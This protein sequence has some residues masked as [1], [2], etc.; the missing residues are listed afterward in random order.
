MMRLRWRRS[1]SKK[2]NRNGRDKPNALENVQKS[3]VKEAVPVKTIRGLKR[4]I[5]DP[6]FNIQIMTVLLTMNSDNARMDRG[7][8]TM[9][10]TV[11]KVRNITELINNSMRSLRTAAE[12]PRQIKQL[13]NNTNRR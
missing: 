1:K 3:E 4:L 2:L 9:T 11:D 10:T 8:E 12:A 13:F 7:L 6:N 5:S